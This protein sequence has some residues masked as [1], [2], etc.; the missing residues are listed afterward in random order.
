VE[1][2]ARVD[3]VGRNHEGKQIY[4]VTIEGVPKELYLVDAHTDCN[5]NTMEMVT[6]PHIGNPPPIEP[7]P[8]LE[9]RMSCGLNAKWLEW[10]RANSDGRVSLRQAM[11]EGLRLLEIK[12]K[13][14]R[15]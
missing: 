15:Q 4:K 8:P 11:E 2:N 9:G 7:E 12:R 10:Y 13:N 3:V 1:K 6:E 5:P 14:P